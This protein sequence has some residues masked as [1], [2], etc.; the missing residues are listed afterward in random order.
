[1]CH[2]VPAIETASVFAPF[3]IAGQI[4]GRELLREGRVY[5]GAQFEGTVHHGEEGMGTGIGGSW[6]HLYAVSRQGGKKLIKDV[7]WSG[8]SKAKLVWIQPSRG[9]STHV[10]CCTKIRHLDC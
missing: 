6:S 3:L 1:M 9:T 4:P 7:V 2:R 8:W 5:F 10:L